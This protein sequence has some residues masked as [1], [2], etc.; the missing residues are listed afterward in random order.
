VAVVAAAAVPLL[1]AGVLLLGSGGN[2]RGTP[3]STPTSSATP[4]EETL[5]PGTVRVPNTIGMSEAEAEAAARAVGL[6][7]RIEW[8]VVPGQT[9]GI[10]A[11]DPAPGT[12]VREGS[13]FV[14]QAY[15][16]R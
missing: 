3:G 14:M 7:W 15:R 6:A 5:A 16:S 12:V 13:P 9:P 4:A 11:Q 2:G 8:R 10:Y 1:I